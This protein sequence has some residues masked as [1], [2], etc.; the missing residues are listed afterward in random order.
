M[1]H[2]LGLRDVVDF[3][4]AKDQKELPHY[5]AV[6][7]AV[8]VP[9]DYESFGMVAL[10]SMASGTPVIASEVGGLA[11][12]V[13]EKETGYLVPVREPKVLAERIQSVLCD[14]TTSQKM[15]RC[16]SHVAKTYAWQNIANRLLAIFEDVVSKQATQ[17]V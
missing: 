13:R 9:S 11:Y 5:Y 7:D 4:G 8:I 14:R 6:A 16:A 2:N 10:E 3:A 15:G 12:L 17:R 1:V